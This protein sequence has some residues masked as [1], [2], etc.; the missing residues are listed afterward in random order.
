M[1]RWK[2]QFSSTKSTELWGFIPN[3]SL[4]FCGIITWPFVVTRIVIP[5][6]WPILR[7][8]SLPVITIHSNT[9][10]AI[11]FETGK[12]DAL[13]I[14]AAHN[15]WVSISPANVERKIEGGVVMRGQVQSQRRDH[16]R[17][18]EHISLK[19]ANY[20]RPTSMDAPPVYALAV[21][22]MKEDP[23]RPR[24]WEAG[25]HALKGLPI[26]YRILLQTDS[27]SHISSNVAVTGNQ[28]RCIF[29]FLLSTV[30]ILPVRN[31]LGFV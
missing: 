25:N 11:D 3:F 23:S 12:I 30:R 7:S 16:S 18:R 2:R 22:E 21:E 5:P 20:R 29:P 1:I 9:Y 24:G 28:I 10:Y 17:Q 14:A 13:P 15:V 31:L 19:P 6:Y 27:H 4:T 8:I 26:R